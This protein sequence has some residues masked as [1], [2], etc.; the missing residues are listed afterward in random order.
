MRYGQ[1]GGTVP[2][3]TVGDDGGMDLGRDLRADVREVQL[4]HTGIGT[5][6]NQP[7]G[8]VA[9]RTEGAEDIGIL[10]A[11]IDGHGRTGAFGRP[12]VSASPFL[13][14]TGFVLTPEFNG[15]CRMR[16]GQRAQCGA[17][18]F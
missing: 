15:F 5:R 2:A 17:E 16:G 18:F 6:E 4:H 9:L 12:S 13:T 11:R 3:G 10:I 1:F 14:D 7:D 8:A